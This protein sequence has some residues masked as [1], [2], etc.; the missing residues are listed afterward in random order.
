MAAAEATYKSIKIMNGSGAIFDEEG[1]NVKFVDI[2]EP[3]VG[4]GQ[5]QVKVEAFAINP[6]DLKIDVYFPNHAKEYV[7]C[8]DASGTIEALGEGVEGFE[9]GDKVFLNTNIGT[10]TAAEMIVVKSSEVAKRGDIGAIEA[11]GLPLVT[12]TAMDAL[13]ALGNLEEGSI[14]MI[15]GA[16]GGV[17]TMAVQ[18]ASQVMKYHVIGIC[19]GKNINMVTELGAAETINYREA[20]FS[21]YD[22]KIDGFLDLAI[23][24]SIYEKA[25]SILKENAQFVTVCDDADNPEGIPA[26]MERTADPSNQYQFVIMNS[27]TEKLN[28]IRGWVEDGSLK[29]MVHATYHSAK[30]MDA[31]KEQKTNRATGKIVVSFE[32]GGASA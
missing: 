24:G 6:I 30:I 21:E 25:L 11:A 26:I 7:P 3:Q 29:P 8:Y 23:G 15:N 16:S 13:N 5:V 14:V 4:E 1:E 22:G 20:D 12:V 28:T 27:N 19:S 18:I 31:F 10:G 2:G 9:V 32:D 17:G